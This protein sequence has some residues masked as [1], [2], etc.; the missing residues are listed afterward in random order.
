[1]P[2]RQVQFQQGCYYHIYN[3]GNN[4]QAIFFETDNYL[5][6]LRQFRH[7]FIEPQVLDVL[8]YCL[9]PNHYH[10][11]V[12]LNQAD[13]SQHM[14]RFTLSYTKAMNRRYERVGSLF[15]G[16]FQAIL[17]DNDRYLA[18]LT[19]Y[20]HLNPVEANLVE[21]AEDWPYS[22]YPEYLQVRGGTLPQ[23][24]RVT[25]LFESVDAYRQFVEEGG[26]DE[27]IQN[28]LFDE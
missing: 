3:R 1:M 22:S 28:L 8:A 16:R 26:R 17:V 21:S 18:H 5:Y 2:Y 11:L 6:F 10:F 25:S 14:Q 13:F 23:C 7:Y 4:R 9:M 27:V 24:E 12:Y 19:R 20:I 15:Q